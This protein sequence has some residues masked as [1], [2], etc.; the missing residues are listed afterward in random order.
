MLNN[1][2]VVCGQ[3]PSHVRFSSEYVA[4]RTD[5]DTDTFTRTSLPSDAYTATDELLSVI[6]HLQSHLNAS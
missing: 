3:A 1:Y 6:L 5:R 2:F 4:C